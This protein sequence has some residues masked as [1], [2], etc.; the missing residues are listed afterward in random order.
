MSMR[1]LEVQVTQM[2]EQFFRI[3][4]ACRRFFGMREE[5][6]A[7]PRTVSRMDEGRKAAMAVDGSGGL[8]LDY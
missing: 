2:S 7:R 8:D 3:R 4:L 6:A 1:Q 5:P